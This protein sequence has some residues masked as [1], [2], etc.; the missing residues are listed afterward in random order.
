[1]TIARCNIEFI[2]KD[3]S[4]TV[5]VY[6]GAISPPMNAPDMGRFQLLDLVGVF[7]IVNDYGLC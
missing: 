5:D 7:F 3:S 6:Q 2:R 1:M 4:T